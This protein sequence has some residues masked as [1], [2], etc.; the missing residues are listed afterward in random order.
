LKF[1]RSVGPGAFGQSAYIQRSD[2]EPR[3]LRGV[4]STTLA[5]FRRRIP[6]SAFLSF[7]RIG[8]PYCPQRISP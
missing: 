5:A 2:A 6:G 1:T 4:S 8:L 3:R 7:R